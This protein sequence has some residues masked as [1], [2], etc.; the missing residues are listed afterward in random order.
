[1]KPLWTFKKGITQSFTRE[2]RK[3]K[4]H[5]RL[6]YVEGWTPKVE[7]LYFRFGHLFHH[8]LQHAYLENKAYSPPVIAEMAEKYLQNWEETQK[9]LFFGVQAK[10][11]AENEFLIHMA[12]RILTMYFQYRFEDF[13][14]KKWLH[15]EAEFKVPYNGTFLRGCIDGMYLENDHL[16]I[17]DHKCLAV[18]NTEDLVQLLPHDTQINL[19]A[20][21]AYKLTGKFPRAVTYNIIRK[22]RLKQ[23]K[24]ESD[25]AYSTRICQDVA[26]RPAHYFIRIRVPLSIHEVHEWITKQLSALLAE[27]YNWEQTGYSPYPYNEDALITKYG[28][29]DF[30]ELIV[31]GNT[32]NYFQRD[33]VFPELE[34]E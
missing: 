12:K 31:N 33:K 9:K 11:K 18:F 10:Q 16:E 5:C 21:A 34:G 14:N 24:D 20:F 30:Y 13:I 7:P 3:C 17:M 2:F 22:S 25:I 1:M 8:I 27:I 15:T 6:R 28:R 26:E 4:M 32:N 29:S 19:Y 23:G